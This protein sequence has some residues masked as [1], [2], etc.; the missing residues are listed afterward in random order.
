LQVDFNSHRSHIYSGE[1]TGMSRGGSRAAESAVY[2]N[3]PQT[4]TPILRT[5]QQSVASI[6]REDPSISN[7]I[8]ERSED[9]EDAVVSITSETNENVHFQQPREYYARPIRRTEL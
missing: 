5:F 1:S 9:D 6:D 7:P 4:R 8:Y 3:S 2:F